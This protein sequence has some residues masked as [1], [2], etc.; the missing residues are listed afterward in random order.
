MFWPNWPS[1]DVQV[2]MVKHSAGHCN[3]IFF[4]P[5]VVASGYFDYVG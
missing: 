1:S 3:A 2:V 4:P 5:T